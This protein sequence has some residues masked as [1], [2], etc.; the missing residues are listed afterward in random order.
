[1]GGYAAFVWPAFG[2]AAALMVGLLIASR[3]SLR[4]REATLKEL[5]KRR[6]PR[7]SGRRKEGA[8]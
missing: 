8:S 6:P 5:E 1:M 3:R 4:S 2:I 7:E